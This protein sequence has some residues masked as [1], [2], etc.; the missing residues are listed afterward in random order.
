MND[1]DLCLDVVSRSRQPLRYIRRLISQKPLQIEAL[2]KGPPIGNGLLAMKWSRDR[3]R[4]VTPKALWGSTVSHR[5]DSLASC[6]SISQVIGWEGWVFAQVNS[7]SEN[8]LGN[9]PPKISV[10][11]LIQ[12]NLTQDVCYD[13]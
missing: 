11:I 4:H 12:L 5:S 9:E 8:R 7:G 1:I 2:F 13:G 10:E 3:C 6:V